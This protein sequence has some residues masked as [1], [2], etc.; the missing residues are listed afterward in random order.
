MSRQ[1]QVPNHDSNESNNGVASVV[2]F[3][4]LLVVGAVVF[5]TFIL[6]GIRDAENKRVRFDENRNKAKNWPGDDE[7]R[8]AQ[9]K[10]DADRET[11]RTS[12]E[13]LGRKVHHARLDGH[14]R[15][16]VALV[17][18][19]DQDH[20]REAVRLNMHHELL[21]VQTKAISGCFE[22]ARR[23]A[24][25]LVQKDNYREAQKVIESL[26]KDVRPQAQNTGQTARLDELL[27]GYAFLAE[28][29]DQARDANAKR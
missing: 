27:D 3:L 9:K 15:A 24:A 16:L 2:G 23:E 10:F 14:Y 26:A 7:N 1:S 18:Q 28:L 8:A 22:L 20:G 4:A 21:T 11:L 19:M 25:A 12:L 17:Q 13:E 5:F 6:P 29:A